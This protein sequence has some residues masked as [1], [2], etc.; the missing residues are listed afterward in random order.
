MKFDINKASAQL[1]AAS[2]VI[3]DIDDAVRAVQDTCFIETGDVAGLFFSGVEWSELNELQRLRKLL[4]YVDY[5]QL[6][7]E[8]A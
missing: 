5:E 8:R 1:L 7:S 6:C 3:D 4:D 2:A